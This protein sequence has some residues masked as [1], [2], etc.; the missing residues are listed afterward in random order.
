MPLLED[1]VLGKGASLD[2]AR[3]PPSSVDRRLDYRAAHDVLRSG[4]AT[5]DWMEGWLPSTW[6]D[7]EGW[8]RGLYA[9]VREQRGGAIKGR[10]GES[11]DLYHDCL[12]AQVGK[13]RPGLVVQ[14]E[15]VVEWTFESLHERSSSVAGAWLTAGV[16]PGE[17][18]A[19]VLPV[20]GDY[21]VAILAALR[22]GLVA[23][24]LPP[25]GPTYV[26]SRIERLAPDHIVTIGRHQKGLPADATVLPVSVPSGSGGGG[27]GASHAYAD[28][29][30][31]LRLL[32]P[33]GPVDADPVELTAGA[34]HEALLRDASLVYALE[35][36]DRIAAPGFDPLQ[37]QPLAMLTAW[38]AG[39]SWVEMEPKHIEADPKVLANLGVTVL[40]ISRATREV[41]LRGGV[42]RVP[43]AASWFRAINDVFD[44]ERWAQL[45]EALA[46]RKV[47]S[48][49]VLTNAASGGAHLFSPR[50][51]DPAPARAWPAPGRVFQLSQVGAGTLASLTDAGTYTPLLGKEP[52]S[53][54]LE[55][56]LA[57]QGAG[58]TVG[59]SLALGP[60]GRTVPA[61]EIAK[62]AERHPAV[63][64]AAVVVAP[65]RWINDA[66]VVLLLF[67]EPDPGGADLVRPVPL[68]EITSLLR[69]E[70][71]DRQVPTRVE[72]YGL[73]PRYDE[74]G[75]VDFAWARSQY[76]SG[77]LSWK[78]RSPLF[79]AAARLCW[80]FDVERRAP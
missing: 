34:L 63:R 18:V 46:A 21:A 80:I 74:D 48:F 22:L 49:T 25:L 65:A 24:P 38:V 6:N 15:D 40:G 75:E 51:V 72:T 62:V 11:I 1:H 33:F 64:S 3:A 31:V 35:P 12:L 45:S 14:D 67:V 71:G 7:A 60:E 69:R 59:G 30:P 77:A 78:S 28:A 5:P 76:L 50:S 9:S 17:S 29:D 55:V 73:R 4:R 42:E 2:P 32:S 26:R 79:A 56:V 52:D 44:Y 70:M 57:R 43:S 66:Q 54:L 47:A 19:I 27:L 36:G 53:S 20:G 37:M 39:A 13:R 58:W 16:K 23:A 8:K 61:R 10:P 68:S 41:L